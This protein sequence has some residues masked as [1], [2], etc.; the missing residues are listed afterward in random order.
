MTNA[1]QAALDGVSDAFDVVADLTDDVDDI[2]DAAIEAVAATGRVGV[3]LVTRTVRF[4]GRHP[5]QV[6]IAV[7]LVAL[8]VAVFG[9]RKASGSDGDG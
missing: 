2:A 8:A 5:R 7:G 6:L 4:V 9:A 3:R 1:A